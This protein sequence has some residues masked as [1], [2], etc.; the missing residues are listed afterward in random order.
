MAI[1]TILQLTKREYLAIQPQ[2]CRSTL[3]PSCACFQTMKRS[4]EGTAARLLI[5]SQRVEVIR[6]TAPPLSFS[7]AGKWDRGITSI[8]DLLPKTHSTTI[9][10]EVH[11]ADLL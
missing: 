8:S 9:S 7:V 11:W 1:A 2:F 10:L 3:S 5:L 4:M 6:G